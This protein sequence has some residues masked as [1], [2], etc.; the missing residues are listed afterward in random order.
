MS[1][2]GGQGGSAHAGLAV[3]Q[4]P[5]EVLDRLAAREPGLIR[6]QADLGAVPE[7]RRAEAQ[8][9]LRQ[10]GFPARVVAP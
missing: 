7:E 8:A 9:I 5:P 10:L 4:A 6:L 3:V 2:R 1:G